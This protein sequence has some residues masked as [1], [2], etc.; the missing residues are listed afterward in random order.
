MGSRK[1]VLFFTITFV[2]LLSLSYG[3][4]VLYVDIVED[5]V[6]LVIHQKYDQ[7]IIPQCYS[8]LDKLLRNDFFRKNFTRKNLTKAVEL[9]KKISPKTRLLCGAGIHSKEDVGQSLLLGTEGILIGHAIPKA[10]NPKEFLEK[11]L[12]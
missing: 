6:P 9:V 1:K 3:N 7:V 5:N 8:K 12:I 4:R 2:V 10:K 11:M